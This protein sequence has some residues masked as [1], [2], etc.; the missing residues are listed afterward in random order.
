MKLVSS[1][2]FKYSIP[3]GVVQ[4]TGKLSSGRYF[5]ALTRLGVSFL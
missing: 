4:E 3:Q 2:T 1:K 5:F